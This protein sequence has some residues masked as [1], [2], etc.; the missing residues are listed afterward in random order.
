MYC[1]S[2]I[3]AYCVRSAP[4]GGAEGDLNAQMRT[5]DSYLP[6]ATAVNSQRP[7]A[8]PPPVP[9]LAFSFPLRVS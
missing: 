6:N 9:T 7:P 5:G 1:V 8:D 3:A 4:V 2:E